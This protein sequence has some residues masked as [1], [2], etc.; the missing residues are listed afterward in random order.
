MQIDRFEIVGKG[1]ARPGEGPIIFC[2]GTGGGMLRP[3]SDLELSHWRP[4]TTPQQYRAGTSTEICF[5]FLEHPLPGRWTVAVNNHVDVDGILSVY[6]LLHSEHALAHRRA[7]IEAAEMGDF[8]GW[9][10]P[11]AQRVFQGITR[12]MYASDDRPDDGREMYEQ[13][14]RR[15]PGLLDGTDAEAADLDQSLLPLRRGAELVEQEKIARTFIGDRLAHY[16][17]P[18]DVAG[19]DD[20]R[21]A[22]CPEFNEAISDGAIFWPQV[23]AKFDREKMCLVSIERQHG[24]F[25]DLWFPGYLWADTEGLWQVPG[26]TYRDGMASYELDNRRLLAAFEEL[27]RRDSAPGRWSLGGTRLPFGNEMQ[28]RFPLAGRFLDEQGQAAV[29]RLSP[30]EVAAA[31]SRNIE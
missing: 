13:A 24:W 31:F 1:S 5:R 4:N 16:V 30:E 15:I 8:W 23:R 11:P 7:I 27:Q 25:H 2:D 21:A 9:G 29:S 14:F 22:Y 18:L 20:L 28:D 3:E 19:D 10:E 12:L 26:L 17:V 6:V